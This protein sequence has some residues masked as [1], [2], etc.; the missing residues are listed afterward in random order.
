MW[1][2]VPI[3]IV[4]IVLCILVVIFTLQN[5]QT[6]KLRYHIPATSFYVPK[7]S[8]KFTEQHLKDLGQGGIPAD[9][10]EN[11]T[12]LEG[13]TFTKDDFWKAVEKQIGEGKTAEHKEIILKYGPKELSKL[14]YLEVDVVLV[15]LFSVLIGIAIMSFFVAIA[16]IGWRYYARKLRR[17]RRKEQ[18]WAPFP[19]FHQQAPL[20]VKRHDQ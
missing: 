5:S 18:K 20:P 8:F 9:V 14:D 7:Q 11:L 4:F 10:L 17:L 19:S 1:F 2:V 13:Q 15:I 12:P 16:G 3:V 6:V